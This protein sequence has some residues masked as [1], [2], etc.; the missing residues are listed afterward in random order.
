VSEQSTDKLTNQ[1]RIDEVSFFHLYER[2]W[3]KLYQLGYKYL[4][5]AYRAEGVVQEVFTSIWQRKDSLLLSEDTIENYLVRAVRFRISRIYSDEVR[6]AKK[7]DELLHRQTISN[8]NHTEQE[9]LYRFLRE[10]ID[11]LVNCLPERCRAVYVLSREKGLNNQEIA[12][13]L[14]ISEKTVENQLTKALKFI[15]KGLEK[16]PLS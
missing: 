12:G 5:D 16:Y 1:L 13:N 6:K 10:D 7:M 15:R 2:Y 14:L 9:V 4:G 3:K 11:K 8:N